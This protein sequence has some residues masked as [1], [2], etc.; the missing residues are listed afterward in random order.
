[1][2][3]NVDVLVVDDDASVRDALVQTVELA[4]LNVLCAGSFVAAKDQITPD[5]PGV[6]LSD[7]RMPGRAGIELVREARRICPRVPVVMMTGIVI[8]I[9]VKITVGTGAIIIIHNTTTVSTTATTVFLNDS[10]I[11]A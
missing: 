4:D 11:E 2:S 3:G 9:L 8:V 10:I 5:F 7:I 6:I 1:M